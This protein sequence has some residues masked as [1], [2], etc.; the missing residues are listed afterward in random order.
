M[1][2]SVRQKDVLTKL[3]EG[4]ELGSMSTYDGGWWMQENGLGRG[5]NYLTVH[6]STAHSLCK[7]KLI[8]RKKYSFPR[9]LWQ[10]TEAGRAAIAEA[11]KAKT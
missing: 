1:K 7:A 5:G 10:I 11:A 9:S 4:W 6:S 2:L 8:Y 3:S